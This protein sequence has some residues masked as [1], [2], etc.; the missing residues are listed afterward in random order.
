MLVRLYAGEDGQSH[1]EDLDLHGWPA[2]WDMH[3]EAA[4]IRFRRRPPGRSMSWHP[5]SRRQ[6]LVVLSGQLE[7][8]VGDGS[9]RVLSPGDVLMAEDLTGQGHTTRTVS[10]GPLVVVTIPIADTR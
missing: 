7:V 2:E 4:E 5:E 10:E 9:V 3:V 1:F 6:Y 8:G